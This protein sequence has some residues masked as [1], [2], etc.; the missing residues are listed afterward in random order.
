M[1]R[2]KT[3]RKKLKHSFLLLSLFFCIVCAAQTPVS[4]Q[5]RDHL[6]EMEVE[7]VRDAQEIDRRTEVFVKA[8]NRHFLV[9]NNDASQSKQIAKDIDLWGELPRGTRLQLF[10]DVRRI[11]EEAINNIDDAAAHQKTDAPLFRKAVRK[12]AE[13]AQKYLPAFKSALDKTTDE[14]ETGAIL[15]AIE[16]CEQIIEASAK[17]PK[18]EPKKPK[19]KN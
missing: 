12:L 5:K 9:L 17:L 16:S 7:L 13:A 3:T 8:I 19:N 1:T 14:K 10:T 11:L 6:N 4:A 2:E 15:A 18:E